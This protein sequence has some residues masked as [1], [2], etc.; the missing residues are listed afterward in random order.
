[1]AKYD[2]FNL[3]SNS[4][5][6]YT[7]CYRFHDKQMKVIIPADQLFAKLQELI[8]EAN[9]KAIDL[10]AMWNV[11]I[12]INLD[13]T[14]QIEKRLRTL[15]QYS[16]PLSQLPHDLFPNDEYEQA[17]YTFTHFLNE[18]NKMTGENITYDQCLPYL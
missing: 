3:N 16:Q 13:P 6:T 5:G 7:I 4:N 15:C 14:P 18:Y 12:G 1:M 11:C 9:H 2:R 17:K 8:D 10:I